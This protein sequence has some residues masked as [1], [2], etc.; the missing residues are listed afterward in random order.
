MNSLAA[1]IIK[2]SNS[3]KRL[4]GAPIPNTR[5]IERVLSLINFMWEFKTAD[6]IRIHLKIHKKSVYRYLNLLS[7]LGFEV[8]V[9]TDKYYSYRIANTKT[10]FKEPWAM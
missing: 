6:E 7:Q 4:Q 2:P 3:S 5:R 10:Y 8:E 9:K 1:V